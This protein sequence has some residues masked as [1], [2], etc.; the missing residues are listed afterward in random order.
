MLSSP[1]S[2]ISGLK[3]HSTFESYWVGQMTVEWPVFLFF[4]EVGQA[5]NLS[6]ELRTKNDSWYQTETIIGLVGLLVAS[7]RIKD[8][9]QSKGNLMLLDV[10]IKPL[11]ICI[12]ETKE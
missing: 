1:S 4:S 5:P 8:E 11:N 12:I 10:Y 9:T 3:V 7:H 2:W 6:F